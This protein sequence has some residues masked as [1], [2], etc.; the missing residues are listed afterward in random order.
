M[1][2]SAPVTPTDFPTASTPQQLQWPSLRELLDADNS[3]QFHV[4]K[5]NQGYSMY[6]IALCIFQTGIISYQVVHAHHRGVPLALKLIHY[7]RFL[8][9]VPLWLY[10][11]F[12]KQ[13]VKSDILSTKGKRIIFL[14][15][16]NIL[17]HACIGGGL[18][19]AWVLTHE[20]CHS[21]ICLQDYPKHIVPLGMFIEATLWSIAMAVFYSVHHISVCFVS[22]LVSYAMVLISA[23]LLHEEQPDFLAVIFMGLAMFFILFTY[24]GSLFVVYTSFFKF[25]AALRANLA[26]EN[27]EALLKK[28]T[29]EMRHMIGR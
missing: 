15:N 7:L 3:P 10:F 20:D 9:L 1:S 28:Q 13:H 5:L 24:E 26:F 8:T 17:L 14:G 16:M 21:R 6:A 27:E 29:E 11:Y 12:F 2:A 19:L 23:V 22:I 4:F 25:E 18:L